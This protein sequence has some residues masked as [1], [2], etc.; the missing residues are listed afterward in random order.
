VRFV[1]TVG[2]DQHR[3]ELAHPLGED[4]AGQALVGGDDHPLAQEP[5]VAGKAQQLGRDLALAEGEVARPQAHRHAVRG[6]Q[7]VQL[8]APVPARVAALQP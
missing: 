8:E 1:A 4:P 5:V 3:A 2:P 6:G 7:Q